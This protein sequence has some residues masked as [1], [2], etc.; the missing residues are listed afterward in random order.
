MLLLRAVGERGVGRDGAHQKAFEPAVGLALG[1]A[2]V[3]A[4]PQVHLG[5]V[6]GHR[7]TGTVLLG[8]SEEEG[9]VLAG[10]QVGG[11]P[12]ERTDQAG[13]SGPH[14][15][16]QHVPQP[17]DAVIAVTADQGRGVQ[18]TSGAQAQQFADL[19]SLDGAGGN[20]GGQGEGAADVH[21]VSI[22][23]VA[24]VGTP[25][26]SAIERMVSCRA[27][28]RQGWRRGNVSPVHPGGS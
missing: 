28:P 19:R 15:F 4:G 9:L 2:G 24:S 18:E 22:P 16:Q 11:D 14:G 20:A 8:V 23:A 27:A 3:F 1:Q 6:A 10:D 7:G 21:D 17:D 12:A 26:E 5:K 25:G 13:T